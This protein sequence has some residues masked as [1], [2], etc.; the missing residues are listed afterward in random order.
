MRHFHF[1]RSDLAVCPLQTRRYYSNRVCW[2]NTTI[3][4]RCLWY[5]VTR[6]HFHMRETP[7]ILK[8]LSNE[9]SWVNKYFGQKIQIKKI[10]VRKKLWFQIFWF[11]KIFCKTAQTP[12]RHPLDHYRYLPDTFQ[13]PSRHLSSTLQTPFRHPQD[14]Q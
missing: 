3:V 2:I 5:S 6:L 8:R 7:L 14:T 1:W 13:T 12:S 4:V 11:K 10:W 9:K